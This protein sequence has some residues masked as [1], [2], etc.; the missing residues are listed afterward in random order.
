MVEPVEWY[1]RQNWAIVME[2]GLL[3]GIIHSV[4][5]IDIHGDGVC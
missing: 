3:V 4:L 5:F 2:L 1:S